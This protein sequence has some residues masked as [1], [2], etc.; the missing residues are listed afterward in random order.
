MYSR[1]VKMNSYIFFGIMTTR[2]G[3][4]EFLLSS[5]YHIFIFLQRKRVFGCILF[6]QTAL[7]FSELSFN[8]VRRKTKKRK[9]KE[10]RSEKKEI[11]L[12]NHSVENVNDSG[13]IS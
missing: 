3:C 6:G 8:R 4:T 5:V 10:K 12:L 7:V 1:K 11:E 2:T 13:Q 9:G